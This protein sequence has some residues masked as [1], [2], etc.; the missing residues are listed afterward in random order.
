[1]NPY[2]FP[3]KPVITGQTNGK[4]GIKYTY[5]F[6]VDDL[7]NDDLFLRVDWGN[8][9]LSK[10]YGPYS[11]GADVNLDYIWSEKGNYV[12]KAQLKDTNELEGEWGTLKVTIPRYQ[13]FTF[14]QNDQPFK[15]ISSKIMKIFHFLTIIF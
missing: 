10:W 8:G 4:V 2:T 13:S 15:Y 14:H 11:S 1:M 12:I 5:N 3:Y 6:F 7:D 9:D